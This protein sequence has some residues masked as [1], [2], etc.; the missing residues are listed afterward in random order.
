MSRQIAE[1]DINP[2]LCRDA[3]LQAYLTAVFKPSIADI[4][5][6]ENDAHIPAI[7]VNVP[8]KWPYIKLAPWYDVHIGGNN[9]PKFEAD[10]EWFAKEPYTLGWLGGDIIENAS[11]LSIGSGVYEQDFKPDNQL[12]LAVRS[13]AAIRHKLLFGIQGNHEDRSNLMGVDLAAWTAGMLQLPYSPD[14]VF[15]KLNWRGQHFK[16]TA[17]HGSGGA[18]TPG[19]QLNAMRRMREFGEADI[20]WMGHLHQERVDKMITSVND[21]S[22]SR[23]RES[24]FVLSPSYVPYFGTYAAKKRLPMGAQGLGIV[25]LSPDGTMEYT[26]QAKGQRK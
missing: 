9:Q 11:K 22:A 7:E 17:H 13:F 25:T 4:H 18:A 2:R 14:F 24:L 8:D 21:G 10:L 5:A 16:I 23:L 26:M 15:L 12:V 6:Y 20:Y 19:A 3:R 1:R